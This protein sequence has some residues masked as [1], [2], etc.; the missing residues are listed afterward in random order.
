MFTPP[1]RKDRTISAEESG[2]IL[3]GGEYG[4]LSLG[5][6]ADG[7]AYGIPISYARKGNEIFFHCAPEGKKLDIIKGG[8]KATFCVVGKTELSPSTFSTNYES[9]I[10]FGKLTVC[11]AEEER[12]RGIW[13]IADKYSPEFREKAEKYIAGSMPR[14]AILKLEIEHISGKAKKNAKTPRD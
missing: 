1:R 10:A 5:S 12:M 8:A 4:F 2:K 3:D 7:Y 11:E 13:L 6:D 9:A 14:T